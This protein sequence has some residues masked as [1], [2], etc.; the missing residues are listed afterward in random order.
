[1]STHNPS[2]GTFNGYPADY[3]Q[4]PLPAPFTDNEP[5]RI[6]KWSDHMDRWVSWDVNT[7]NAPNPKYYTGT[8]WQAKRGISPE[9]EY[10]ERYGSIYPL[11]NALNGRSYNY[12]YDTNIETNAA[13][14]VPGEI[15]DDE[16]YRQ[17]GRPLPPGRTFGATQA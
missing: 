6:A 11:T 8:Q 13:L 3:S 4:P 16:Y 5:Y 17:Y 9:Q 14:L 2:A 12:E 15:D 7:N 10:A 1:M